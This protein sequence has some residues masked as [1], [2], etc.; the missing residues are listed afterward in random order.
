VEHAAGQLLPGPA[1]AQVV[2]LLLVVAVAALLVATGWWLSRRRLAGD[3]DRA[4]FAALH[5]A[6]LAAPS[7]RQGLTEAG[8]RP[9]ARHLRT[10]LAATA[11]AVV[12]DGRLLAWDGGSAGHG[13]RAPVDAGAAVSSGRTEVVSGRPLDC[14]DGRCPLVAAVAAPVVVDGV[15]EG[16]LIAYTEGLP[17]VQLVRATEEVAR[18]VASQ[19]ALAGLDAERARAAEAELRALRDQISPHF[20]YNCLATIASFVRTDPDRA[21]DL[22][23]EFADFTRYSFRRESFTTLA[24]ELRNVER[25]LVL[26]QARFGERLTVDLRISREVLPVA[27]PLLTVQPLVEN[28]V[29]HGMEGRTGPGTVRVE[30]TDAGEDAVISVEDDGAGAD[31][32]HVRAVLDGAVLDGAIVD[33]AIVDGAVPGRTGSGSVG[34]GNVDSRLRRTFG[35]SAGLV[36]ET[37][38]GAGTR[39]TF[40]VPKFAPGVRAG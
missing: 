7:L 38:P 25:Y 17:S 14:G 37:A 26:E 23:L 9:A 31:P 8:V 24:E 1:A 19:V 11:V 27:I 4:A 39:V 5:Q 2:A 22:L 29:R 15:T 10:L 3:A 34:L 30:A 35:D 32:D 20:V 16:V 6:A 40:R 21:R 12:A 36:V 18:W 13:T 33:G 28:A